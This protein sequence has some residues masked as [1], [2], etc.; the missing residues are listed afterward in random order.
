MS[1]IILLS[2]IF[3]F[4]YVFL[5]VQSYGVNRTY[6][7]KKDFIN[8]FKGGEFTV[9][10]QTGKNRQYRMESKY[11]LT[12][13]VRLYTP[14]K[15]L[16]ARLKAKITAVMYKAVI[17]VFDNTTNV[18]KNGTIE[19]NYKVVG[20]KFTINYDSNQFTLE[21]KAGSLDTDFAEQPKGNIVATFHKRVT[22]LFWRN[23]YDLQ[24]LTNRYPDELF[25][26]GVAVRDHSNK[27]IWRG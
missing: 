26:L 21:S 22:S 24:V 6:L 19:Q 13:D 14:S 5:P 15:T 17:T 10:D 23:K 9:Y 1:K 25:L 3:L 16:A 7:V 18:W 20:S 27:K 2:F 4:I 12:H 11:G 8:G